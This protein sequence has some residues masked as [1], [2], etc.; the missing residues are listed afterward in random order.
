MDTAARREKLLAL[1]HG[2][3]HIVHTLNLSLSFTDDD[4][5][6]V[7]MP[8]DPAY[9]HAAGSVHGGMYGVLMDTA[10]W[11]TSAIT[12]DPEDWPAT[13]E[14]SVHLLKAARQAPLRAEG[15]MIKG[16]RRQDVVEMFLYNHLTGELVGHATG[17]FVPS[18]RIVNDLGL[19]EAVDAVGDVS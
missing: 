17:T 19:K 10:G 16:G 3:S 14:L 18:G 1:F 5:P 6:V 15:R 2:G 13:A 7:I 8:Y 11:F 12:R 9:D 4:R